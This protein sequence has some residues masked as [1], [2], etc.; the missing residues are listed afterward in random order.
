M[1]PTTTDFTLPNGHEHQCLF[2][3]TQHAT[4]RQN[5][6]QLKAT[7]KIT[8]T[9]NTIYTQIAEL[10]KC[11]YPGKKLTEEEAKELTESLLNGLHPDDYG[12]WVYYPWSGRLVHLLDET[13]FAQ[14]RTNRN[15][16]KITPAE[17]AKLATRRVGIIGLSVG[18]AV[19]MAM[20]TERSFGELRLA[21]FD[22]LDLSNLNRIRS[23]VHH[24][25]L[26]K[27]VI[28]ARE[29][30]ELDPFL[31]VVIFTDGVTPENMDAF[32][33]EGGKL[34]LLIDECDS[35]DVKINCRYR[36]RELRIPVLMETSDR[37]M[38]D[39]E[40]YDLEPDRPILHG[41]AGGITPEHVASLSTEQKVPIVLKLVGMRDASVRGRASMIEIN[42][43]LVTWPQ[44]GSQVLMGG[45]ALADVARN[46]MTGNH[47]KSG[48]YYVDVEAIINADADKLTGT[49]IRPNPYEELTEGE[50]KQMVAGI[51]SIPAETLPQDHLEKII[52]A[53]IA[54]PSTGNDQPWK[55]L[56]QD[57]TLFLFHEQ[58]RSFSFGD[59]KEI[60]S[61]LTFGAVW[62]NIEEQAA[63]LGYKTEQALF[64][65]GEDVPVI[66][67]YQFS[68]TTPTQDSL[69]PYIYTRSSNRNPSLPEPVTATALGQLQKATA[70][71]HGAI[72]HLLQEREQLLEVGKII[73]ACD[74]MR[75]LNKEGHQDF[76]TREIRWNTEEVERTKDGIDIRTLGLPPAHHVLL[77]IIKERGVTAFL[78][79]ING[80]TV[81]EMAAIQNV[82]TAK[83]VGLIT[84]PKA[85]R[86]NYLYGGKAM[87]RMWLTAEQLGLAIYPLISPLYFFPRLKGT[88]QESNIR[89]QDMEILKPL[90][91]RFLNVFGI[92]DGFCQAFLFKVSHANPP[93][94]R[95]LRRPLEDVLYYGQ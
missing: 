44:L 52:N 85:N 37:G 25:G 80:G 8:F 74:R 10:L 17:Q 11:R 29:I 4:D 3:R 61:M 38:I 79:E 55:W 78:D 64:P 93:A 46:V 9:T 77:D 27:A 28:A 70:Q 73:G 56:W 63:A 22:T 83:G 31:K 51:K 34:D 15:N 58:L 59:Y 35:L 33:Q 12:V 21:D 75:F 36:A 54:A 71:E 69:A 67:S 76:V 65:L 90:Q 50:M 45:G 40:R 88:L 24:L 82:L 39:I 62:E 16:Y 2:F 47:S 18:H 66:A 6:E 14:L 95:A 48:R 20:A 92:A 87:E 86:T 43:T 49:D 13:E 19:A 84:L 5:L 57:N 7:G 26:N 53:G 60:A 42:Q 30:A 72:L 23:S 41:L 81:L 94:V 1:K 32:L 68:A 91:Q 89:Q